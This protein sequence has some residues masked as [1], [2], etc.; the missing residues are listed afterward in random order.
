MSAEAAR[1]DATRER[2]GAL[3]EAIERDVADR[4]YWGAAVRVIQRGETV[5]DVTHGAADAAGERPLR[6]DSVFTIMSLTKAFINVLVLRAVEQGRFALTTPMVELV[7]GFAGAPRDRA[8]IAHFL[9]HT[10]GMPGVW[11][12]RPDLD[13]DDLD[14]IVA[15]VLAGV[16]GAVEP[17]TRCDYAPMANHVLMAEALRRTDPAGRSINDMLEQDL[18]EPLGM[19]DTRLGIRAH[20][21]DRHA[22]LDDRGIFPIRHRSRQVEGDH[23]LFFAE[24]HEMVWAGAASTLD[25][26]SRFARMLAAGG[27]LDGVRILSPVM[28][29][30]ARRNHTGDL[31]NE[32]YRTVALRAGYEPPP[33]SLGL[34]FS[35][36]GDRL[37][38]SQF[39]TLA[40][41]ETFGNYGAGSTQYWIDPELDLVFVALTTG[42]MPAAA[43]IDRFQRL[44][45]L[46]I[47]AA[48][49]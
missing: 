14:P 42:L 28:L 41:P 47:A 8:T 40:S 25:D 37:V 22:G 12:A 1:I 36:R 2:M 20:L 43:N 15:A 24:R 23:G 48:D 31:P 9:T 13:L 5:L 10:T 16:H 39:G 3:R 30:L 45:D 33:A 7:P 38:R 26:L 4:R 34:G 17:G 32:L 49:S 19:H 21:R 18:F 44:S 11:E 46:A 27:E 6:P 35:L 29:R